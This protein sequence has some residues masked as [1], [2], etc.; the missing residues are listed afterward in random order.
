MP[1][2]ITNVEQ[3]ILLGKYINKEINKTKQIFSFKMSNISQVLF[4]T[5]LLLAAQKW[6]LS[7]F[8]LLKV[9]NDVLADKVKE[10]K[11]KFKKRIQINHLHDYSEADQED[12]YRLVFFFLT[13]RK[14][15]TK[16]L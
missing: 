3:R 11:K 7:I 14:K 13:Q 4:V 12:K 10:K 6:R 5:Y 8:V 16:S 15:H 1:N 9:C 2:K